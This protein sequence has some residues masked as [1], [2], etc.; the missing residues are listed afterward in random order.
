[1]KTIHYDSFF[2][3]VISVFYGDK[4]FKKFTNFH[5]TETFILMM[6]RIE[7]IRRKCVFFTFKHTY[8][9]LQIDVRCLP[10]L[11]AWGSCFCVRVHMIYFIICFLDVTR[12]NRRTIE[13]QNDFAL[14]KIDNTGNLKFY[15][16]TW[17]FQGLNILQLQ[18]TLSISNFKGTKKNFRDR[19]SSR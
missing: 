3:N 2:E 16:I 12:L 19:E 6:M 1:M 14:M 8:C 18:W 15:L 13:L 4:N 11:G 7:T 17:I 5:I 9:V 10:V